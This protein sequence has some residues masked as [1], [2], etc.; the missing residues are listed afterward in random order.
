MCN[1][2]LNTPSHIKCNILDIIQ[3]WKTGINS[4]TKTEAEAFWNGFPWVSSCMQ[5][6][7]HQVQCQVSDKV[8]Q[9]TL[10]LVFALDTFC[11]VANQACLFGSLSLADV[12]RMLPAWLH[13]ASCKVWWMRVNGIGPF[14]RVG[15]CPLLPGK[16]NASVYLRHFRQLCF[17]EQFGEGLILFQHDC[18]PVH[19]VRSIK[20][21]LIGGVWRGRTWLAQ[22]E[23]WSQPHQTPLGWTWTEIAS[24]AFSSNI[25]ALLD[26]FPLKR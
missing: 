21:W 22:T 10:P 8:V 11:G 17:M 12:R 19:K 5:T 26:K 9:T 18:A 3:A 23:P 7:Q 13:Y 6:L 16:L 25:S 1:R 2:L 24:R 4:S 15:L 14:S 20:T